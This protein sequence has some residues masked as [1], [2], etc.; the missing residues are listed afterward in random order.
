LL[1]ERAGQYVITIGSLD[2]PRTFAGTPTGEGLQF[3]RDG[4]T[5]TIRAGG[6]KETG[7][8]WL[9]DKT[10]CLIVQYGEGYCRQ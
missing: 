8:K 6:G 2:G 4:K 10:D 1:E 5:E 3:T 7:M 9:M